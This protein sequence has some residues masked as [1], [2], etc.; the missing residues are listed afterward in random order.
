MDLF[1]SE[2]Q[3]SNFGF[4]GFLEQFRSRLTNITLPT[5]TNHR[6]IQYITDCLIN[7]QL[8]G[9][10]RDIFFKRGIQSL[11]LYG[12]DS[13]TFNKVNFMLNDTD[14]CVRQLVAALTR[15][16][17]SL[18]LTL[19]CNQRLHPGVAPLL[20]SIENY[21]KNC[22]EEIKEESIRSFMSTIVRCWSRSMKYLVSLLLHSKENLLGKIIKIWARA[23][24]QT[25]KGNLPHYHILLWVEYVPMILKILYNVQV[26]V[27]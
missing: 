1:G 4:A 22:S 15:D 27:F 16:N 20:S 9:K 21:F 6:Y 7:L 19:T 12:E 26:Q 8:R 24:F 5:S 13:K 3:C 25:T 23:E 10:H 2:K 17:V 18:F 14:K 11:K